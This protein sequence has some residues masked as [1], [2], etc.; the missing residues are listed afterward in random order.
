MPIVLQW[1][2]VSWW[3]SVGSVEAMMY[4]QDVGYDAAR[5]SNGI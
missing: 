5:V 2:L 3:A 4:V 1:L